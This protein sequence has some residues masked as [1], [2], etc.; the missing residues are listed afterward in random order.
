[1]DLY[2]SFNKFNNYE[3]NLLPYSTNSHIILH[4]DMKILSHFKYVQE[5]RCLTFFKKSC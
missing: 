4:S 3:Y 5:Q 2:I 1:M